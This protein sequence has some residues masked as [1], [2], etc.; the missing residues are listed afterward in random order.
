MSNQ[1]S[2]VVCHTDERKYLWDV[3]R[4]ENLRLWSEMPLRVELIEVVVGEGESWAETRA[5]NDGGRRATSDV[6]VF[7]NCD[8][9]VPPEVFEKAMGP[10]FYGFCT[11]A[12]M[13]CKEDGGRIEN[14][15]AI[16]DFQM[17][18]R[19]VLEATGGYNEEMVGWGYNDYDFAIRCEDYI[20]A[21]K[22]KRVA[23]SFVTHLWHPR[24]PDREARAQNSD[25]HSRGVKYRKI[26]WMEV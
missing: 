10:P 13:D 11:A 22:L 7:T 5:K 12:R 23:S 17:V 1:I 20:G 9:I 2:V 4:E 24:L 6:V 19:E 26:N 18:T 8:I 25:N 21:G 16:G 3:A 14:R 15:W